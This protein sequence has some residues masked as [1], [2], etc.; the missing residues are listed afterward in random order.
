MV[1]R[2]LSPEQKQLASIKLKVHLNLIE[3]VPIMNMIRGLSPEQLAAIK[4]FSP[5]ARQVLEKEKYLIYT[6]TGQSIKTLWEAG[7]K[8]WLEWEPHEDHPEVGVLISRLTEVA[9][10]P[11]KFVL[12]NSEH[13]TLEKQEIMVE[14]YN[15]KLARKIP[16]VKAI[17]SEAPD[18]IELVFLHLEVSGDPLLPGRD[19]YPGGK[20]WG[21][22]PDYIKTKTPVGFGIAAVGRHSARGL[23]IRGWNPDVAGAGTAPLVV[24]A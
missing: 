20:L 5:E 17:I 4:R 14:K 8:I 18:Y 16:D 1:E 10:N 3:P 7:R 19:F 9:I 24:P 6:L 22:Y 21:F 11:N 15:Q 12:P 13:K 23:R 2:G